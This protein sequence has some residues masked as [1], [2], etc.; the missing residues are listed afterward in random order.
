M[1]F[2]SIDDATASLDK[3]SEKTRKPV[4]FAMVQTIAPSHA[5]MEKIEAAFGLEDVD[6][7][8]I[9]DTVQLNC[10][11]EN[12]ALR[13]VLSEKALQMHLERI[14]GAYVASA[15]GAANFYSNKATEAA[16]LN[17]SFACD[18]RDEDRDGVAGFES[19]RDRAREFA[20]QM[21]SQAYALLAAAH[22]S[23]DAYREI[24][25]QDWKPY[26]PR[27][28]ASQRVERR[29][30]QSQMSAFERC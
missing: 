23:I 12:D 16:R 8:K 14:V 7:E 26:A 9:R 21:A 4:T 25:G 18:D 11:G 27:A 5:M 15:W 2:K 22:G 13:K 19:K 24:T 1:A 20:A 3:K 6:Y 28:E 30:A 29:S 10:L 17:S